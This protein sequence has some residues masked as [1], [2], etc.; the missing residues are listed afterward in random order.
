MKTLRT[1]E[2]VHLGIDRGS[3]VFHLPTGFGAERLIE[4][5][6]RNEESIEEFKKENNLKHLDYGK[7]NKSRRHILFL[8]FNIII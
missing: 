1:I 8:N 3:L 6:K 4:F 2:N 7:A 5:R